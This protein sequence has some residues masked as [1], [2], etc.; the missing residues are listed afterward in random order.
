[1]FDAASTSTFVKVLWPTQGEIF[2][3]LSQPSCCHSPPYSHPCHTHFSPC[4]GVISLSALSPS[5][6]I[7]CC[8]KWFPLPCTTLLSIQVVVEKWLIGTC[9]SSGLWQLNWGLLCFTDMTGAIWTKWICF[10]AEKQWRNLSFSIVFL[11]LLFSISGVNTN[12]CQRRSHG[13]HP[14]SPPTTSTQL[15]DDLL[16]TSQGLLSWFQG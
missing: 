7:S 9:I 13:H 4:R 15:V 1:M 5:P 10:W 11:S 3:I 12:K 2:R 8:F 16:L 6:S 14:L